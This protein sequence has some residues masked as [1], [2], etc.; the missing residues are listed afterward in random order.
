MIMQQKTPD[1]LIRDV[2]YDKEAGTIRLRWR[3]KEASDFLVFIYDSRQE[4]HL[5]DAC[6]ELAD[7]GYSDREI[8]EQTKRFF[9]IGKETFWKAAYVRKADFQ[10]D[11]RCFAFPAN[12]L[13]KGRPYGI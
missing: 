6:Q 1:F 4:F 9:S 2:T 3:Y 12:E 8:T 5:A 11:G 7:A 13:K 10:R